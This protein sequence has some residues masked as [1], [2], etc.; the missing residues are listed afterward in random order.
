MAE[1]QFTVE[2]L[3]S[4]ARDVSVILQTGIAAKTLDVASA[5]HRA[6]EKH[7]A[8]MRALAEKEAELKQAQLNLALSEREL[9]T[10]RQQ[11]NQTIHTL[12]RRLREVEQA[13]TPGEKLLTIAALQEELA[14]VDFTIV[15]DINYRDRYWDTKEALENALQELETQVGLP[16]GLLAHFYTFNEVSREIRQEGL[17]SFEEYRATMQI[18]E[19]YQIIE[20]SF[21]GVA[22]DNIESLETAVNIFLRKVNFIR[23]AIDC[24]ASR[25]DKKDWA[26]FKKE[27]PLCFGFD[28]E[29]LY[30]SPEY[31]AVE[32]VIPTEEEAKEYAVLC[33]KNCRNKAFM[34][35]LAR[36]FQDLAGIKLKMTV[37]K[38]R[39]PAVEDPLELL[40]EDD[41]SPR[42]P[43]VSDNFWTFIVLLFFAG[44]GMFLY[45]WEVACACIGLSVF[46]LIIAVIITVI[47]EARRTPP[48][49]KKK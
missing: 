18:I 14:S 12:S 10:K 6:N 45:R 39:R 33:Q 19:G 5:E 16:A 15:T 17:H 42:P 20:N 34:P 37:V 23:Y 49:K 36:C 41:H 38:K 3:L 31:S 11:E 26:I 28:P 4:N 43:A 24:M 47:S 2:K 48:K 32:R 44:I 8:E 13:A 46:L 29:E 27:F 7:R 40:E 1:R 22:K 9:E 21:P 35:L 25:F 30:N